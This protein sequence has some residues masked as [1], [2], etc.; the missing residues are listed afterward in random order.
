MVIR[1]W[2]KSAC[3]NWD[4]VVAPHAYRVSIH[5]LRELLWEETLADRNTQVR[6]G[7]LT[8]GDRREVRFGPT[9]E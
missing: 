6:F 4:K 3:V 8:R 2:A 7:A 9:P 1:A 5:N